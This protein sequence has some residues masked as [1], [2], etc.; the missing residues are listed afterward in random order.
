[1][2]DQQRAVMQPVATNT[3]GSWLQAGN[4]LLSTALNTWATVES[5]KAQ[6]AA[7]G[8]DQ[9]AKQ[10]QPELENGA[11]VQVDKAPEVKE[12]EPMKKTDKTLLFLSVGLL[13]V[14]L[15]GKK[16]GM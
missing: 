9:L 2:A 6:R 8:G 11:A 1:M 12:S 7:S 10:L 15:Y 13:A 4:Q 5:V 16:I 14:A 3:A